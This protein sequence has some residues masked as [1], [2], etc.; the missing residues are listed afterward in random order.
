MRHMLSIIVSRKSSKLN[1]REWHS[2]LFPTTSNDMAA[3]YVDHSTPP[4]VDV[5]VAIIYVV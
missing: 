1:R 2:K 4:G 5:K 3:R